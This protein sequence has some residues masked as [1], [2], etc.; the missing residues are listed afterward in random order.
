MTENCSQIVGLTPITNR[1]N[2]LLHNVVLELRRTFGFMIYLNLMR[3]VVNTFIY[4]FD[5]TKQA[6]A[7]IEWHSADG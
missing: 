1:I 7:Y 5:V 3:T 4:T 2:N 6:I